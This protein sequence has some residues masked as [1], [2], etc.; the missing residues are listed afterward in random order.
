MKAELPESI[1][2]CYL[3]VP[4]KRQ[5]LLYKRCV[6]VVEMLRLEVDGS[7]STLTIC[8]PYSDG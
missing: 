5:P 7:F 3:E 8:S 6:Q 2:L 4:D 1:H